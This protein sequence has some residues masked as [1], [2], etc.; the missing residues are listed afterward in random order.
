MTNRQILFAK[1]PD[2]WVT[3]DCFDQRDGEMPEP[4]PG[5]FLVRN[6]YMSVDPYMRGMMNPQRSYAAP[7]QPGDVMACRV[8]AEVL[9]S[10]HADYAKGD[11]VFAMARWEEYSVLNGSETVRKIDPALA[12]V[13]WH[14]GVL[15]APGLTAYVGMMVLLGPPEA[16][17]QVYVSSAAGAVGQV[18]VQLAKL[19]GARVVGSAGSDAKV[20]FL[21]DT[22]GIDG[23]FNYKTETSYA[24]ALDRF[25][26]DGIDMYF[27][28]VGGEALEAVIERARPF[29]RLPL[30][31]MI[32]RYNEEGG[33]PVRNLTQ[34]NR[35]RL[36]LQGYIVRDHYDLLPEYLDKMAGWLKAGEVKYIEDITQG[37]ENAPEAFIAMLKGGNFGK[38]VVQISEDPARS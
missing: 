17:Q 9:Q 5:E 34:V 33:Y 27:D 7:L 31:G 16:G 36:T 2:G 8:V 35:M 30:C 24:A 38:Q 1:R 18:A 11:I 6:I 15:G 32:S 28:N 19:N 25:F 21:T 14:L 37:L 20:A 26:P 22:L 13:S 10:N 29:A 12:P 3:T 23:A 4:G